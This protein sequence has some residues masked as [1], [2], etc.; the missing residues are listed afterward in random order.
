MQQFTGDTTR[1]QV[2]STAG[3]SVDFLNPTG[4]FTLNAGD[5]GDDMI[6]VN[7]FGTSNGG[8][9]AS[10]TGEGGIGVD[11]FNLITSLSLGTGN[12]LT[13]NADMINLNTT[14]S[15]VSASGTGTVMLTAERNILLAS[16]SSI[17][18]VDGNV[19]LSANQLA[20]ATSGNFVGVNIDSATVQVTGGGSINIAGRGGDELGGFE[21][22]NQFGVL[23]QND[24][25][26]VGGSTGTTVVDGTGGPSVGGQSTTRNNHGVV[27]QDMGKVT[28][29]GGNVEVTGRGSQVSD[30]TGVIVSGN[31]MVTSGGNTTVTG[32]GGTAGSGVSVVESGRIT[33]DGLGQVTVMG[34][35]NLN[36]DNNWGV[37]VAVGHLV[38]G[39]AQITSGGGNVRVTGQ[40]GGSA[41]S[42]NNHGVY[43]LYEGL[44]TSGGNGTVTV[45][46]TGGSGAGNTSMASSSPA[47]PH[48]SGRAAARSGWKESQAF[49][50]LGLATTPSGSSRGVRFYPA[51]AP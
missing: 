7:G 44:I 27:V 17:T 26:I 41:A 37:V 19:T 9:T 11:S 10:F 8:M 30:G 50:G 2:T 38:I 31:G 21:G 43:V 32:T 20:T 23:I 24:G 25:M 5:T 48:E 45:E 28:S 16:G 49:R 42:T 40:G 39:D 34:T 4:T 12:N 6:H 35:G 36:G 18:T 47:R 46:G 51:A 13:V 15:D 22:S 14:T 33:S 3:E 29:T 1:T